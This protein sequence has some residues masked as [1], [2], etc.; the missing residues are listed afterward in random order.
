[1]QGFTLLGWSVHGK[2]AEVY[3]APRAAAQGC[4]QCVG[5]SADG[6]RIV[7]RHVPG[8]ADLGGRVNHDL[9][10]VERSG[11]CL[12][13]KEVAFLHACRAK[14]LSRGSA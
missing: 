9:R 8:M 12:R 3:E 11:E 4:G 10:T 6:D 1:M 2:A 13:A 7:I 14:A 5:R